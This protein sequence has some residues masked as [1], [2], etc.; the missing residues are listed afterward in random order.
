MINDKGGING[1]MINFIS[2]DDAYSP[3]KTVEQTRKLIESDEVFMIFAPLGTASNAAIQKYMNPE[4]GAATLCRLRCIA[5]GRSRALSLDHR[6]QPSYRREARIYATYILQ[7]LP[8]N[9]L[10]GVL[11]RR[12]SERTISLG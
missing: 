3:P 7:N 8:G 11:Y 12:L 10:I 1:R 6:P 2:Y 9:D 5:L 4:E